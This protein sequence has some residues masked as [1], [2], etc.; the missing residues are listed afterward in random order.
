MCVPKKAFCD[1]HN[2][3]EDLF[4]E[5]AVCSCKTYMETVNP[6]KICD[7]IVNCWDHSDEDPKI[8]GCQ[9]YHN[10]TCGE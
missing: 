10:I 9:N 2:N 4:D 8:C 6:E 3:C 1:S 5:P 7:G